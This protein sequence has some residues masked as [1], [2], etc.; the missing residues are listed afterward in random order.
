MSDSSLIDAIDL[1]R[2]AGERTLLDRVSLKIRPGDRIGLV[3]ASG[4]GKSLLLR[5]IALLEPT[6]S[7]EILF[8]GESIEGDQACRYRG[9]VVYLQ[10]RAAR[11]EGTVR[12]VLEAPLHLRV[13]RERQFDV[14]GITQQLKS[15]GRDATFLDQPHEQLSGGEMQLVAL[16]RAIQLDPQVLLLD[17]PTSALD[18]ESVSMVERVVLGWLEEQSERRTMVW[19]SHDPDQADRLCDH[20]V[21]M[22]EGRILASS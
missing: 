5:T 4:S 10:Q 14:G 18:P 17:E 19:V 6:D 7:G 2:R 22:G 12:E 15:V 16:L 3:G 8:N 9:Q 1:F 20:L 11:F 13:H 21:R